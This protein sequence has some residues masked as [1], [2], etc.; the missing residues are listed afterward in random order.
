MK[1]YSQVYAASIVTYAPLIVLLLGRFG[2]QALE[3]DV[4]LVLSTIIST[5]GIIWQLSHRH[6]E[7]DITKLGFKK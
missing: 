1:N 5:A 7:G 2:I 3:S 4:I 6:S